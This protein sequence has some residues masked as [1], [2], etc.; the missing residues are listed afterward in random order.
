MQISDALLK[1]K[2][3]ELAGFG[4]KSFVL[5]G[6]FC[7]LLAQ[8]KVGEGKFHYREPLRRKEWHSSLRNSCGKTI[9]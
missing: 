5:L 1:S 8:R 4:E 6:E 2:L 7:G 3:S 9:P